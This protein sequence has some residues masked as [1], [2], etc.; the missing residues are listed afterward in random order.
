MKLLGKIFIKGLALLYLAMA[1]I[2]FLGYFEAE[3]FSANIFAF[4]HKFMGNYALVLPFICLLFTMLCWKISKTKDRDKEGDAEAFDLTENRQE[5]LVRSSGRDKDPLKY[6]QK[7]HLFDKQRNGNGF[8]SYFNGDLPILDHKRMDENRLENLGTNFS[9]Y[10]GQ[11]QKNIYL[12]VKTVDLQ[13][14][15]DYFQDRNTRVQKYD[16]AA[17]DIVRREN[18]LETESR[19]SLKKYPFPPV[20]IQFR[21]QK[22]ENSDMHDDTEDK[23]TDTTLDFKEKTKQKNWILPGLEL[24]VPKER[25]ESKMEQHNPKLLED[26][27]STYGVTAKVI[28]IS[29]GPVTTRYEL[30]PAPGTKISKIVN[31]ADDIALAMASRDIRIE[32]PIPGKAAVGIEIPRKNPRTVYF[33]E[34]IDSENFRGAKGKLKMVLGKDIT[35]TAVIGELERM[36]H[37][38]VAGATGSGK[39]IFINC[40]INS[41][42]YTVTPDEVKLLLIDPKMVELSQYNGIPHLLTPVVTDPK[43]ANKY[44]KFIVR[45]MENRY[46][47]FASSGV[48]DID[49][50][51]KT[52]HLKKL[53]YIVVIIDEL[54]DLM[55]AASHEIEETICR[56]AQMARAAGIHLVIATQRP[57]VNVITGLIK[58]NIPSRISFAVSSQIDSRTILD[59][60]GAEKLLGRGDMLYSPI[61]LSKPQRVHGCFIDEQE[62]KNVIEH[63]KNQGRPEFA[64]REEQLEESVSTEKKEDELDDRFTEAAE[65]VISSGVASVSFLQ[66]RLRVG[67]SRAARLMDMLEEAGVVGRT[68]GSKPRDILMSME[69]F[70]QSYCS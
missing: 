62:V 20:T 29:T 28:H 69:T 9:T 14:F 35:D 43:K 7:P 46:E 51:H 8:L 57:S 66:R 50:Y 11:G 22:P 18:N 47:L 54:A 1:S 67:Y 53:P 36:P 13:G 37:L 45:E 56:L 33:R 65:L 26:V 12:P 52:P 32:A 68:E 63:W 41:L 31:L 58:A 23:A 49:H 61:G 48:R 39:S 5:Q 24:L 16:Q 15:R 4:F 19:I 40:L 10:F 30:S 38:L 2:G 6:S 27:L 25:T 17:N 55:M 3:K 34:V 64:I 21:G 60:S 42:L 59:A 44:L 70:S